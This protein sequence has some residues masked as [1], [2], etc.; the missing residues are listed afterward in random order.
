MSEIIRPE[1]SIT[2]SESTTQLPI[3]PL[4]WRVVNSDGFFDAKW[5]FGMG[6]LVVAT[7]LPVKTA[8]NYFSIGNIQTVQLEDGFKVLAGGV[9]GALAFGAYGFLKGSKSF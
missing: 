9:L 3:P 5:G 4:W 2:E 1:W 8:F 6:S 7:A